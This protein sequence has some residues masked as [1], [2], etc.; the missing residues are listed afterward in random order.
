MDFYLLICRSVSIDKKGN[1]G[2]FCNWV[3]YLLKKRT[4]GLADIEKH[5]EQTFGVASASSGEKLE[6]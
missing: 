3:K 4:D 2:K 6:K 5:K 1:C